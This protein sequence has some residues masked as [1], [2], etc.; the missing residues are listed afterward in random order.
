MRILYAFLGVCSLLAAK[1]GPAFAEDKVP[2]AAN[3]LQSRCFCV[4]Y[5]GGL[6]PYYLGRL[7]PPSPECAGVKYAG[8][9]G[10]P[11]GN[12][13]LSCAELRKCVKGSERNAAKKK[14]LAGKTA[15]AEKHLAECCA[16][17]KD[18]TGAA[19]C[20]GK[21]SANWDAILKIL[22]AETGKLEKA[23]NLSLDACISESRK[24]NARSKPGKAAEKAPQAGGQ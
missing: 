9:G 23:G 14:I 2:G 20:G 8:H 3:A 1:A 16:S 24:A 19:P 5:T 10:S 7:T 18:K 4:Q 21:C 11:A 6:S 15:E 13:L 22:A 12:G 17:G